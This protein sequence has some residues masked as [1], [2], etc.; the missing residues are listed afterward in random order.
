MSTLVVATDQGEEDN[1]NDS[2]RS[3]KRTRLKCPICLE[4]LTLHQYQN[5]IDIKHKRRHCT[6]CK[7]TDSTPNSEGH[8]EWY[9]LR[10]VQHPW[11]V[12]PGRWVC[13]SC[14]HR[15]YFAHNKEQAEKRRSYAEHYNKWMRRNNPEFRAKIL[16]INRDYYR[17]VVKPK[18]QREKEERERL[19]P[20][21]WVRNYERQKR[22]RERARLFAELRYTLS[23]EYRRKSLE[24]KKA[25][26]LREKS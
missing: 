16:Q 14:Q 8:L 19:Q 21:L 2:R 25:K 15:S 23:P 9:R 26:K 3:S 1:N 24:Q 22:K 11:V 17:R 6:R 18:R 20:P 5:H 10:C 12:I 13:N 7:R 4:Y